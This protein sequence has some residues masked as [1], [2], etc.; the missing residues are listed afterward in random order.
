[1]GKQ[2]LGSLRLWSVLAQRSAPNI[3]LHS[4]VNTWR[5]CT[6][7]Q[8]A[9][10]APRGDII[11]FMITE[12]KVNKR[13]SVWRNIYLGNSEICCLRRIII[14]IRE[15]EL[16]SHI[17]ELASGHVIQ[18][19]WSENLLH[20]FRWEQVHSFEYVAPTCS[21][22]MFRDLGTHWVSW[23][24]FD[25]CQSHHQVTAGQY[26]LTGH[27]TK[28]HLEGE[29]AA[30][31]TPLYRL[32]EYLGVFQTEA[33]HTGWVSVPAWYFIASWRN[34]CSLRKE[35]YKGRVLALL[36]TDRLIS[37]QSWLV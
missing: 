15:G 22:F 3:T 4:A 31:C 23:V 34:F 28:E 30:V 16:Q 32:K 2:C 8:S 12:V 18:W 29:P 33:H 25:N 36:D 10:R 11:P 26:Q 14:L 9:P 35:I 37:S 13:K 7:T 24:L 1:M 19:A 27:T 21:G 20:H 5:G 17:R 6:Q